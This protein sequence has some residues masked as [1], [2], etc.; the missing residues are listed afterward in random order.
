MPSKQFRRKDSKIAAVQYTSDNFEE[1]CSMCGITGEVLAL[2]S[3][4]SF[5]FAIDAGLIYRS[6]CYVGDWFVKEGVVGTLL[7]YHALEPNVFNDMY[8]EIPE[9]ERGS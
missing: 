7:K 9:S 8:E 5:S 3:D 1:C 4:R 6:C 2:C